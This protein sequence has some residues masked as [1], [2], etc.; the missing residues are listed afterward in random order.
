MTTHII[1]CSEP[2]YSHIKNGKKTIE[3]RKGTPKWIGIQVGDCIKFVCKDSSFIS[4]VSR[5]NVYS[6]KDSLRNYLT[7]E[8]LDNTLPGINTIDEGIAIYKQ[9]STQEE[10][11]QYGFLAIHVVV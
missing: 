4:V 10:I 1:E 5:I 6:G 2:W 3:G 7:T 9:W 11:T 8:G